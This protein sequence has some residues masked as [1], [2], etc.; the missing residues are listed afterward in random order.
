MPSPA[1]WANNREYETKILSRPTSSVENI[2]GYNIPVVTKPSI[3]PIYEYM[4]PETDCF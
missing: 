1:N 3:T 4:V 2:R